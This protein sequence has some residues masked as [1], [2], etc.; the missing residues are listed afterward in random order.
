M[1]ERIG[2]VNDL[3]AILVQSG[4]ERSQ[5][6]FAHFGRIGIPQR[7][8]RITGGCLIPEDLHFGLKHV[9]GA[10]AGRS[11][12]G[13]QHP[14]YEGYAL[15]GPTR[16]VLKEDTD[17]VL[18]GITE[19]LPN[20]KADCPKAVSLGILARPDTMWY[21]PGVGLVIAFGEKDAHVTV[22]HP[23]VKANLILQESVD[24]TK[25][26]NNRWHAEWQEAARICGAY[27]RVGWPICCLVYNG[28]ETILNPDGTTK[29]VGIVESEI[30]HWAEQDWPVILVKG[31]GRVCDKLSA[32]ESFLSAHPSVIVAEND[33]ES[34]R[35]A[36]LKSEMLG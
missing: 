30:R 16:L 15:Y 14:T 31:S 22:L 34:I 4:T 19:I 26:E 12:D 1:G 6:F 23:D 33:L 27:R 5:E 36:L 28:G 20:I 18:P 29:K 2:S 11:V 35:Q 25:Q 10:L 21:K 32:D 9:E 13:S 17:V 8:L 7:I 3:S 24:M